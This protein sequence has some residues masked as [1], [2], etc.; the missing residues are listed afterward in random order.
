MRPIVAHIALQ[1]VQFC[2]MRMKYQL[3][4]RY[5]RL[6]YVVGAKVVGSGERCRHWDTGNS[7]TTRIILIF[8]WYPP[9]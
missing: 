3:C 1:M 9:P 4:S 6:S 5:F 7:G 8:N 2:G